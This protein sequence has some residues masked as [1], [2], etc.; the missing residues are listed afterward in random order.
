M[1]ELYYLVKLRS[2]KYNCKPLPAILD[3]FIIW[4]ML[5]LFKTVHSTEAVEIAFR[6]ECLLDFGSLNTPYL[7][8]QWSLV[9]VVYPNPN[10]VAVEKML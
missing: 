9:T 5:F 8:D 10:F 6:S 1:G 2:V 3:E 4:L 7:I